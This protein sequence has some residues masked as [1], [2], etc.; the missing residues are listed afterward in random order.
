[1]NICYSEDVKYTKSGI[2]IRFYGL[3]NVDNVSYDTYGIDTNS[4]IY[5]IKEQEKQL[6]RSG[7]Y[8]RPA[9]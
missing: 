3:S 8:I 2:P 4:V 9:R 7:G 6:F 1:M 5:K